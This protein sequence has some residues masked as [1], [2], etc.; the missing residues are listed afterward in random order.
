[1]NICI[2]VTEERGLAS[3]VCAHFGSAPLFLVVDTD[4]G[5][6]RTIANG[7]QHHAHGM[8]Q[9]LMVL[10]G[11]DVD[12]I[13]V[14]GIGMGALSRL[15]SAQVQVFL[16]EHATVGEA[17]AAFKAGQLRPMTSDGACTH[18]GGENCGG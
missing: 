11:Q 9:P 7:N 17:V 12:G 16:S 5:A 18:H 2:P 8:C 6:C 4:S 14:G 10:E 1:M 15:R 13:V 3:S